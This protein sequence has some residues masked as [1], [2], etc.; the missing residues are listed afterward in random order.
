MDTDYILAVKISERNDNAA[1]VQK[2]L[3]GHGCEIRA[4]LGAASAGAK[5]LH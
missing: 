3:T 4:R 5:F 2:I 1:A